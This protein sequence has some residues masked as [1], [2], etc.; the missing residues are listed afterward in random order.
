VDASLF[1]TSQTPAAGPFAQVVVER[2]M[3]SPEG[4]TYAL[5]GVDGVAV[6]D[7][8]VV[9]LGRG[10]KPAEGFVVEIG[11]TPSFDPSKIK[12]IKAR[13]GVG[14]PPTLIELAQW[15]SRYYC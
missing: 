12:P 3:D 13:T 6:G 11:V 1:P 9:P 8:V 7:R 2:S 10:D 15:L 5:G 14:L 4:L